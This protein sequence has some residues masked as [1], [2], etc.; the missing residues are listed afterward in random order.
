MQATLDR[1]TNKRGGLSPKFTGHGK[2]NMEFAKEYYC[3]LDII[4]T[5]T[6]HSTLSM[7]LH[8]GTGH[9]ITKKQF[10]KREA[11]PPEQSTNFAMCF[12]ELSI[13]GGCHCLC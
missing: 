8:A 2:L 9:L 12:S 7:M 11:R 10:W 5:T 13:L 3:W 1:L 4:V 6:L